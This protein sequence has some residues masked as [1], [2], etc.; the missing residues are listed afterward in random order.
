MRSEWQKAVIRNPEFENVLTQREWEV[1]ALVLANGQLKFMDSLGEG[2]RPAPA[3]A[4]V[5]PP[6][7]MYVNWAGL[8]LGIVLL[9]VK[10]MRNK[11]TK[12]IHEPQE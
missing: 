2:S 12:E 9:S 1:V 5:S 7:F 8:N 10:L 4:E 11:Q 6:A 3:P